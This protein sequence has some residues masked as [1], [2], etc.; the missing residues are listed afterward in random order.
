MHHFLMSIGLTN[1][2]MSGL[3]W[4]VDLSYYPSV[5]SAVNLVPVF[6]FF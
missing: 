1:V 3:T 6:F 4:G 5:L 2:R